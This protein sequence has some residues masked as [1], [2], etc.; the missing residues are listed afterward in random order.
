MLRLSAGVHAAAVGEDLVFLDE[1]AD[2]YLCVVGARALGLLSAEDCPAEAESLAALGAAGLIEAG[3]PLAPI[4]VDWPLPE[5]DLRASGAEVRKG[6]MAQALWCLADA[7]RHYRGRSFEAILQLGRTRPERARND[8]S[9]LSA[10]A[11]RF[12]AWA[13]F[14]PGTSKCLLRAFMLL[15]LLRREGF[16]ARWVFAVRTWPFAAHCWLQLDDLALDG[17]V[18]RLAAYVPILVV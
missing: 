4:G 18:E 13:P 15:R 14:A 7:A 2:R 17:E 5:R 8:P 9:E 3:A 11:A 12:Q 10:L 16:D 1:R 6:D